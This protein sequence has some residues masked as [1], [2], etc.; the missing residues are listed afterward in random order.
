VVYEWNLFT[1]YEF[2][3]DWTLEVGYVG[4]RGVH[5]YGSREINEAQLVGNPLGT[6]AL[7]APAI[8][9]GLVTT[10]TT[11]NASLRVPYLGYAP[12]GL[13]V[14]GTSAD[15]KYNSLQATLRKR[16]SHGLQMEAAYTWSRAFN[17]NF[18][19]NDP[20]F[21]VYGLN[22]AY[23]PQRLA[24]SYLWNIPLGSHQGLLER[25]TSGWS[26]TGVTV[27][28]DGTPLTVT[29]SRGG[30]IYGFGPGAVSSTAEYCA[31]T[32]PGN[33]ASNGSV[34]Q[35][36]GGVNGGQGWFNKAA[37]CTT[38]VI[39]NGT[40]YGD[41]GLGIL[42]GPGQFNWDMS[43]IKTTR[44]GGIHEDGSLEFRTE[45]FNAF[46]HPQFSN[47]AVLDASKATFGQIT[48][49]SVNP[50]LVQFA[51]KYIF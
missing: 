17:T 22:P 31:G 50:R 29:D 32:G 2:A 46:N 42:L 10:N 25:L 13:Q 28:Q 40:G 34:Q 51:L 45:F 26:L 11:A 18:N 4:S 9:A 20:N 36:L 19:I 7:T 47:P 39:G 23:H 15:T 5:Q 27:L 41:S 16:L 49:T 12:L 21:S 33:V 8:A 24:I 44:V 6:N 38:P 37:F 43:L 3:P 48:T 35:R 30:T 14:S 1:Q